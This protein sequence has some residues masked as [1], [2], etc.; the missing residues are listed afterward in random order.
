MSKKEAEFLKERAEE[1]LTNASFLLQKG[2]YSLAA[3]NLEQ[4]AQLYL[5]YYLFLKLGD[6]PR[7]HSFKDLLDDL[8]QAYEKEEIEKFWRDNLETIRNLENAYLTTRYFPVHFEKEE[9]ER[10]SKVVKNLISLLKKL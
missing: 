7:T 9:V 3:F 5:K 10:M 2:T 4:T 6:Y 1:F 8:G